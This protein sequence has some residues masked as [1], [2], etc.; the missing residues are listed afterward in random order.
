MV[1]SSAISTPANAANASSRYHS[2][3]L[4]ASRATSRTR[5]IPTAPSP[6]AD[7]SPPQADGTPGSTLALVLVDDGDLL[8][9]PAQSA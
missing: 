2:A 7:A 1:V 8:G 4:R 9:R 3:E 5:M 6:T